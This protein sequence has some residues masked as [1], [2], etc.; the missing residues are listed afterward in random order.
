MKSH[1]HELCSLK[2]WAQSTQ[3]LPRYGILKLAWW[4]R[5]HTTAWRMNTLPF[6]LPRFHKNRSHG[7]TKLQSNSP[8]VSD[9]SLYHLEPFASALTDEK[10]RIR[11]RTMLAT[12]QE[13]L[14]ASSRQGNSSIFQK[15]LTVKHISPENGGNW[16]QIG[17]ARSKQKS[18][19]ACTPF[20]DY[21][22]DWVEISVASVEIHNHYVCE[23][24][25]RWK[26][27]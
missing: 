3:Y 24:L 16:W 7:Q 13:V 14:T 12:A 9:D 1:D 23:I 21:R 22:A 25:K 2:I 15:S 26:G 18:N 5:L 4:C 19:F 8:I 17:T 6:I 10:R 27:Q 20:K 11:L